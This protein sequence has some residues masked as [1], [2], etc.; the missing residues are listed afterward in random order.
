MQMY[1][2][3]YNL[4]NT[5]IK[6]NLLKMSSWLYILQT[7]NIKTQREGEGGIAFWLACE[8]HSFQTFAYLQL[9]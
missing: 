4:S 3:Y 1:G 8:A 5:K 6:S 7:D 9:V 2:L